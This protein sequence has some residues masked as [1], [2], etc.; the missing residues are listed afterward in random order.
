MWISRGRGAAA[1]EE[2][3]SVYRITHR[4]SKVYAGCWGVDLVG[5]WMGALICA[6]RCLS[7]EIYQFKKV[8]SSYTYSPTLLSIPF[9]VLVFQGPPEH[10]DEDVWSARL[11]II[12]V[13][14]TSL[15]H[16]VRGVMA[17]ERCE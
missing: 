3:V 16:A 14:R 9:L 12:H 10:L 4:N 11:L 17:H 8:R 13:P 6:D 1:E 5:V 7:K 15:S 2:A